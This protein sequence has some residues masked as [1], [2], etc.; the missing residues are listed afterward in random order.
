V[1][2]VVEAVARRPDVAVDVA[3][4]EAGVG[5]RQLERLAAQ[6]AGGPAEAPALLGHTQ[7]GDRE[8][9]TRAC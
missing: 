9:P 5:Q 2:Q 3:S 8:R 4:A 1:A 7:P 6:V